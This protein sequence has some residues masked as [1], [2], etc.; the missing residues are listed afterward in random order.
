MAVSGD[1]EIDI[2]DL[3]QEHIEVHAEG[4]PIARLAWDSGH[5]RVVALACHGVKHGSHPRWAKLEKKLSE[6]VGTDKKNECEICRGNSWLPVSTGEGLTAASLGLS[7]G[8]YRGV[9]LPKE[10][11][12]EDISKLSLVR[13]FFGVPAPGV[14]DGSSE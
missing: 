14:G 11:I 10:E 7:V 1:A 3:P 6:L 12:P 9:T 2:S 8:I 4:V 5:H 13:A